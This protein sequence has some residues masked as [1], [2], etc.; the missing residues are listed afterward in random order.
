MAKATPG[1]ARPSGGRETHIRGE[2]DSSSQKWASRFAG[3]G[4]PVGCVPVVNVVRFLFTFCEISNLR[5]AGT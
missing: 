2:S 3:S 5:S 1:V 4:V